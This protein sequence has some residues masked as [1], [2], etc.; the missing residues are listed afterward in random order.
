MGFERVRQ[1][2]RLRCGVRRFGLQ[3]HVLVQRMLDLR[4][5]IC[6]RQQQQPDR[7]LQVRRH[8]QLLCGPE[9]EC[10]FQHGGSLERKVLPEVDIAHALIR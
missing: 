1:R 9:L 8:G 4:A 6:K 3:H 2:F 5:Q 10:R 7:L